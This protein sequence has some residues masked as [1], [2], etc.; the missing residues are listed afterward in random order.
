MKKS[1]ATVL[2]LALIA[3]AVGPAQAQAG[4]MVQPGISYASDSPAQPSLNQLDL[5]LP[6]AASAGPRPVVVWVHGGGWMN[7]DKGNKMANK[8]KLFTDAGYILASVNYRLSPDIPPSGPTYDPGRI[9]YPTHP[10]D[11]AAA[12]NWVSD[13]I[14]GYGGDPDALIL[15][16]HSAGAHLVSLVGSNPSWL[17]G[18]GTSLKQ[19]LGVISLDAGALDVADNARQVTVNP[20]DNNY[21]IWNAF[22]N[23][24]EEAVNHRW[25][26]ASPITWADPTD[27]RSLLVTQS[28]APARITENQEM[29]TALGSGSS[30][31]TV[32]LNHEGIN[33]AVGNPSDSTG[34]T[35]AIMAFINDRLGSRVAPTVTVKK[36]PPKVVKVGRNHK[37]KPKKRLVGF[38]FSGNGDFEGIQCL[39]DKSAWKTCSKSRQYWVG[40]GVHT[41][42]IR[43]L[44]PSGRPGTEKIVKFKVKARPRPKHHRHIKR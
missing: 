27:P 29:A 9:M 21:L 11:V 35:Q 14:A 43:A 8:A 26:D 38:A 36:H 5:Y 4:Y 24:S 22:G 18:A 17:N 3:L 10:H 40:T 23:P 6:D 7:G 41:F 34:E 32:P 30:V 42:R 25:A 31:L 44:Y 13:N 37:G 28:V 1:L 12:V 20:T 39:L 19:V 15:L 2:F 33:D 16:G